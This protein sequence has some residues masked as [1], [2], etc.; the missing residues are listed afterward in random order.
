VQLPERNSAIEVK[1]LNF[2]FWEFLIKTFLKGASQ[3][4]YSIA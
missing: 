3:P 1:K 2:A 4:K